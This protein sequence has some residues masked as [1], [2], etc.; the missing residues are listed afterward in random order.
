M[1][2]L[3]EARIL[4]AKQKYDEAAELLDRLL[5]DYKENDEVWYLRGMVSLKLRSYDFAQE[6]FERAITISP[7]AEYYLL[8]GLCH[9][10]IFE[11]E[12]AKEALLKAHS[13]RPDDAATLFFISMCCLFLDEPMSSEYLKKAKAANPKKTRQL[14]T[15]FYTM[16]VESDPRI[17]ASQKKAI[18]MRI[19]GIL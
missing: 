18:E 19:K 6:C 1:L 16:F 8:Q 11:I 4:L 5:G 2:E 17:S 3:E 7:K 13:L 15:N 12:D 10:E 9:F 14:L